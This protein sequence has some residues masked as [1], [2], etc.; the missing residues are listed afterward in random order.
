MEATIET[1]Y[2]CFDSQ[3]ANLICRKV[4]HQDCCHDILQEVY[5]KVIV[6]IDTIEKADNLR[7]YLLKVADNAVVDYYRK[8]VNNQNEFFLKILHFQ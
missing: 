3:L 2:Q 1:I 7:S 6:N 8:K 5:I 4:N